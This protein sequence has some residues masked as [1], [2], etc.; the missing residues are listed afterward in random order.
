MIE[1]EVV[2]LDRPDR[3]GDFAGGEEGPAMEK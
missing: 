2:D 3:A 1:L